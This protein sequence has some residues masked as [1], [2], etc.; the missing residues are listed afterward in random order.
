VP[1]FALRISRTKA[2]AAAAFAVQPVLSNLQDDADH[3]PGHKK[4]F[5]A[6]IR[7]GYKASEGRREHRVAFFPASIAL[8]A[9]FFH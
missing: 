4:K 8:S 2:M 7:Q 5:G 3:G 9:I 6:R 1:P